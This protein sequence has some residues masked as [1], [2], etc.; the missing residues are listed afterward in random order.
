MLFKPEPL[1]SYSI[2]PLHPFT[3]HFKVKVC[4]NQWQLTLHNR[5]WLLIAPT[6]TGCPNSVVLSNLCEF[7][8][9]RFTCKIELYNNYTPVLWRCHH[10]TLTLTVVRLSNVK[11]LICPFSRNTFSTLGM[12]SKESS[13]SMVWEW[14]EDWDG[15]GRKRQ[16]EKQTRRKETE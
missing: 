6:T 4:F 2:S 9:V 15:R 5:G 1:N 14:M 16:N 8:I 7:E 10:T 13:F 11:D 12:S 3:L